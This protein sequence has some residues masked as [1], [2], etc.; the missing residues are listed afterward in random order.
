M[1]TDFRT[2][3]LYAIIIGGF[4]LVLGLFNLIDP[5]FLGIFTSNVLHAVI[6]FLLGIL[7]I[8]S[9]FKRESYSFVFGL[10]VLLLSV[11][12]LYFFEP[13]GDWIADFFFINLPVAWLNIIVGTVSLG[14]I[15]LGKTLAQNIY[16]NS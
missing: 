11:G 14:V 12:G 2:R 9:G 16:P 10:G 3:D 13:T 8:W 4:L 15:F 5:P 6:H 7:G 1:P